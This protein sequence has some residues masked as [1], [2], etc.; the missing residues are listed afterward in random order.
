MGR[1]SIRISQMVITFGPGAIVESPWGPRIVLRD[2]LRLPQGRSLKDLE[3]SNAEMTALLAYVLEISDKQPR[4]YQVPP[5]MPG[6]RYPFWETRRFPEWHLCVEHQILY[7]KYCPKCGDRRGKS[8]R[9]IRF[10]QA[11]PDGHLDDVDWDRV[12][13]GSNPPHTSNYYHWESHGSSLGDIYIRCPRCRR[14]IS[15]GQ[16]YDQPQPCSGRFPERESGDGSP[17]RPGCHRN[18]YI[19]QRQASNLRIPVV[20]SLFTIPPPFTRLHQL[21]QKPSLRDALVPELVLSSPG[22]LNRDNLEKTLEH[23]VKRGRLNEREKQEI[24]SCPDEEIAGAIQDVQGYRPPSDLGELLRQEFRAFLKGSRE[25]IP[26]L[27]S[28]RPRSRV[29]LEINPHDLRVF[30]P[31]RVTPVRRL[32]VVTVQ[33]GYYRRV[34]GRNESLF[35]K[36]VDIS[37]QDAEGNIW[38]PGFESSGEGIFITLEEE[39]ISP[40]GTASRA[41]S[42]AR[43]SASYSY[44]EH[45]FRARDGAELH[46]VF[47]AWHTLSHLLIRSLAVDSGYSAPSIRERIY[48][49]EKPDGRVCGGILLYTATR[50]GD[51]ALGGLLALTPNFDRVLQRAAEIT[52]SCSADPLCGEHHFQQGEMLGAAC[53]ACCLISET[54]CEHRNFWLDRLVLQETGWMEK[55]RA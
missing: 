53:H 31:F 6:E 41:W 24:L 9:A 39:Q 33:A 23:L 15:L 26:P 45:L 22:R 43:Q 40:G 11:C 4:I 29:L 19:I 3:L 35:S 25:G 27:Y 32:Q 18:A 37:V 44:D 46:P 49:E 42:E 30:P 2:G 12:V 47:V 55:W 50:S 13:H 20:F 5:S 54:S 38:F 10:V 17:R 52:Y 1:Q 7:R 51:G 8:W 21:L 16:V 14:A 36:M 34:G 48:L 28:P